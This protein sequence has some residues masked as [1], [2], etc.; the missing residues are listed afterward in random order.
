[1]KKIDYILLF[2]FF[3]AASFTSCALFEADNYPEPAETLKGSIVDATTG[4]PVY[5]DQ[6]EAS[7]SV[8]IRMREL[9]WTATE[10]ATPFDFACLQ[11]G[12][13]Q[14]TKVF[15]GTYNIRVDGPFVP[16]VRQNNNGDVI[17]DGSQNVEIK[18]TTEVKFQVQPFLK[19]EWAG[20]PTVSNGYITAQF[21]ITRA[22]SR[23]AVR[24]LIEPLNIGY[25]DNWLNV[26]HVRFCVYHTPYPGYPQS[27][28][29][30]AVNLPGTGTYGGNEFEAQ[31]GQ[32]ITVTTPAA[33][34]SGR[35]VFVRVGAS[36]NYVLEGQYR[37]N[38]N[39]VLK[40]TIP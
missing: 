34:P 9:S 28:S 17:F 5:T 4:E 19:V 22:V 35:T 24:S 39:E 20:T 37:Y 30:Y 36:V 1:M 33:Y 38:Y 14:N 25:N 15:K 27:D 2:G 12:T 32:T 23:D 31:L 13:F 21:K 8:R 29:K 6:G 18:G 16:L 26:R 40:V 3:F 7:N 11:D 10:V